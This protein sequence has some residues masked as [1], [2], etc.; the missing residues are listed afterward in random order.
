MVKEYAAS[1][2]IELIFLPTY[3]PHLNLIERL[4]KWMKKDCLYGKYYAKFSGF[5]D[6]IN[7]SII[8]VNLPETNGSLRTLLSW[9]FQSFNKTEIRTA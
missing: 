1:L 5:K 2:K 3:T 8:K 9:K 7:K 4:W 6:A